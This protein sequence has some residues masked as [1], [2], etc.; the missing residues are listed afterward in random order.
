MTENNP[1]EGLQPEETAEEEKAKPAAGR[2]GLGC[3]GENM[4]GSSFCAAAG[5]CSGNVY[6]TLVENSGRLKQCIGGAAKAISDE[7]HMLCLRIGNL[8]KTVK[9]DTQLTRWE[10][11]R[12]DDFARLGE[13]L[14]RRK[15]SE[16]EQFVPDEEFKALLAQV[17]EDEEHIRNIESEKT[18]QRRYMRDATVF[19]H[20]TTQL[21][22]PDPR[23]RRA[24]L[25]ILVRLGKAE[26]VSKIMPL[27]KDPDAEVRARARDA[28]RSLSNFEETVPADQGHME[29]QDHEQPGEGSEHGSRTGEERGV[30]PGEEHGGQPGEEHGGQ[31]SES[32]PEQP[33][34]DQ[35]E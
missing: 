30:Q 27:L 8:F 23:I 11:K 26:A 4:A 17:R 16:L 33:K 5:K 7:T 1:P 19:G 32:R 31:P 25:R 12:R 22:N 14:F 2:S 21:T 18:I 13:E 24:A 9:K 20:A 6:R 28:I 34:D 35:R 15:E 10:M 29:E 3:A